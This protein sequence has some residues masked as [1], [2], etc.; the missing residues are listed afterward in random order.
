[1]FR[2]TRGHSVQHIH[3]PYPIRDFDELENVEAPGD[4]RPHT[5][6]PPAAA[7]GTAEAESSPEPPK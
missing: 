6:E 1:M 3:F 2:I 7:G 4:A 5:A